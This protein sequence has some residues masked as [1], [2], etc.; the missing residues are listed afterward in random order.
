[1]QAGTE[2]S[3]SGGGGGTTPNAYCHHQSDFC[4]K[5]GTDE[6]HANGGVSIMM[7]EVTVGRTMV[8]P[9]FS[10]QTLLE[11]VRPHLHPFMQILV[12]CELEPCQ[13]QAVWGNTRIN[14]ECMLSTCAVLHRVDWML[15]YQGMVCLAA[16]QVWWTWEV[17]DIFN[18][19]KAGNKTALKDYAKQLHEQIDDLVVKV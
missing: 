10:W 2:I 13:V 18:K 8:S 9:E 6:S 16:N 12:S 4:I 17:E 11:E 3:G 19:V 14:A 5:I 1:M 15:D 7:D